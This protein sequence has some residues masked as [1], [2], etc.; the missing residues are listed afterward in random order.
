MEEAL[1]LV[2][3]THPQFVILAGTGWLTRGGERVSQAKIGRHAGLDPN[4]TS[5][6][7]RSLEA[8]GLIDRSRSPDERSKHP[9]LTDKG[10][11]VLTRAFPLVEEV[12][13]HFFFS[14][15]DEQRGLLLETLRSLV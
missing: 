14:L 3:L 1:D 11:E 10:V 4:T 8:G 2:G 12:N 6:I 5:Q 15:D 13:V 7:L 9:V